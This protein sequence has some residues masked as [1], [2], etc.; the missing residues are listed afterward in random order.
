MLILRDPE[1]ASRIANS[2][3]RALI[4]L[5]FQQ[6]GT[7]N[8]GLLIVVEVGDSIEELEAVSGAAIL[9]DPFADV[10]FGHPDFTPAFD[11]MEAHVNESGHVYCYELHQDTADDGLGRTLIVPADEGIDASLLAMCAQYAVP[12]TGLTEP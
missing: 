12:A 10:P 5:R 4:D 11:L 7:F 8:D 3:I 2:Y 1:D 9:Y 6:L